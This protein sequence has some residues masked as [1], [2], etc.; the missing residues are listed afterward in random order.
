MRI[1]GAEP[2]E[3]WQILRVRVFHS[4]EMDWS[5][6]CQGSGRQVSLLSPSTQQ[7]LV[8]VHSYRERYSLSG[9]SQAF[10]L[11]APL[12]LVEA[13]KREDLGLKGWQT[14]SE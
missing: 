7:A 2:Q 8:L 14:L 6:Q 5:M 4:V 13:T 12:L 1:L 11:S 10:A 3:G 9:P